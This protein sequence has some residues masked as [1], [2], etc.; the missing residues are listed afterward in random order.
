MCF[1]TIMLRI[2]NQC[3]NHIM[4]YLILDW[5]TTGVRKEDFQ[6]KLLKIMLIKFPFL[7]Q[8]DGS[9]KRRHIKLKEVM[10]IDYS[11]NDRK[12]DGKTH[13][14][15]QCEYI[16]SRAGNLKTHLKKHSGA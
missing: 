5:L 3:T 15:N 11:K 2:F 12:F 6:E 14:C 4:C 1:S 9:S 8:L 10:D 16:S 7:S 13:K